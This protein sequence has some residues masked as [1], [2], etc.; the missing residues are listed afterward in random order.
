MSQQGPRRRPRTRCTSSKAQLFTIIPP[1]LS[2]R[3]TYFQYA[4]GGFR[5]KGRQRAANPVSNVT[6]K[7]VSFGSPP[8]A[9]GTKHNTPSYARA[10]YVQSSCTVYGRVK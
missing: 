7:G 2:G 8:D 3:G 5:E 9:P 4:R 10:Y 6:A 1:Y